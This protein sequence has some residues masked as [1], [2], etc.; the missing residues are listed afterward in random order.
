MTISF[1]RKERARHPAWHAAFLSA[2]VAALHSGTA[3]AQATTPPAS[4]WQV[5]G[6]LDVAATSRA[7]ALGQ[8]PQS[9][10]LGHSD[11]SAGGPLGQ[12][13][14]ARLTGS[15]HSTEDTLEGHVEE[16]WIQTRTLPGGLQA[17]AGRFSSQVGYL[18]EQHPHADDFV[19]RPLLYRASSAATGSTTACA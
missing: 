15:V 12:H 8:R 9:L 4:G 19:E 18:N 7:L 14:D 17:R 13:F 1:A 6:V 16:A 11:L 2:A 3:L 10:G 5:G